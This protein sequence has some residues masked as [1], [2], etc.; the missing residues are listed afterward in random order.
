MKKILFTLVALAAAFSFSTAHAA[1]E[2]ALIGNQGYDLVSYFK[3]GPVRGSGNHS[4][5]YK[6]VTY[7]FANKANKEMFQ[8]NPETYLPAY[9]GYCAYGVRAGRK[10]IVDPLAWKIVDGKLYL[11][12]NDNVQKIWQKDISGNITLANENWKELKNKAL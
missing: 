7:I 12:L 1:D 8:A 4:A 5:A 11:N 10:V 2:I 3:D 9:G 6:G